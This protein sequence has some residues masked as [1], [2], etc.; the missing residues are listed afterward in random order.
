MKKTSRSDIN[1]LVGRS[2]PP[3]QAPRYSK[4]PGRLDPDAANCVY[5]RLALGET[6]AESSEASFDGLCD[7]HKARVLAD[8]S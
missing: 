3:R 4:P 2:M 1:V 8:R 6:A 5:C 7:W